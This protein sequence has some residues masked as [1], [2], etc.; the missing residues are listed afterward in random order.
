MHKEFISKREFNGKSG[1]LIEE[2]IEAF[3]NEGIV[4][5]KLGEFYNIVIVINIEEYGDISFS[6]CID[7]YLDGELDMDGVLEEEI[8]KKVITR[9]FLRAVKY[10][11]RELGI[12]SQIEAISTLLNSHIKATYTLSYS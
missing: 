11:Y 4:K 3:V 1:E 5:S 10:K 12:D 7:T 2:I 8:I 6:E 9:D